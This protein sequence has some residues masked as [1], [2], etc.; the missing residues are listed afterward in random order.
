MKNRT[1]E[2]KAQLQA[3]FSKR[4]KAKKENIDENIQLASI[5]AKKAG[6]TLTKGIKTAD[7]L[8]KKVGIDTGVDKKLEE[9]GKVMSNLGKIGT[10]VLQGKGAMDK[11]RN[12]PKYQKLLEDVRRSGYQEITMK[13]RGF[14]NALKKIQKEQAMTPAEKEEKAR[15]Q[16]EKMQSRREMATTGLNLLTKGTKMAVDYADNKI[17]KATS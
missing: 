4:Q 3:E 11:L 15:K 7:N 13:G 10:R 6:R 14:G 8:Y 12:D 17:N 16:A 9:A 5:L 2:Q 1:P